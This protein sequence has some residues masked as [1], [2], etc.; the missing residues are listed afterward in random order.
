MQ[1]KGVPQGLQEFMTD[2]GEKGPLRPTASPGSP[3]PKPQDKSHVL[4]LSVTFPF[5]NGQIVHTVNIT[6]IVNYSWSQ[7]AV[8]E[9]RKWGL[10]LC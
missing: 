2:P 1:S 5:R 4:A 6:H 10:S 7:S 8:G 3:A 9:S